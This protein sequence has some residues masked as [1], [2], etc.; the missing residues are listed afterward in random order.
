[1]IRKCGSQ[2]CLY[3]KDGSRLLGK[4]ESKKKAHEQEAAIKARQA[5]GAFVAALD[6]IAAAL[7]LRGDADLA[8]IVDSAANELLEQRDDMLEETGFADDVLT[9]DSDVAEEI[10]DKRIESID[11]M[12]EYRSY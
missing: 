8:F 12:Y 11:R 7:E 4:H 10:Y 6:G 3:T 5:A 2:W 9:R 1:M